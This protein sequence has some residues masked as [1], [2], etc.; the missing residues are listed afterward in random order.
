MIIFLKEG[1]SEIQKWTPLTYVAPKEDG[2]FGYWKKIF[3]FECLRRD[4]LF[5]MQTEDLVDR[6]GASTALNM[7]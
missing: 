1:D 3:N 2:I 4:F 7:T 6:D 5:E